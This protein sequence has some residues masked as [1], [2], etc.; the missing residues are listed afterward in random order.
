MKDK[1]INY[2]KNEIYFRVQSSNVHGVGLFAI[3]DILKGTDILVEFEDNSVFFSIEKDKLL[4]IHPNI[5]KLWKDY[6]KND[7]KI[8]YIYLPSNYKYIQVYFMNHSDNPNGYFFTK[9]DGT[10]GFITTRDIKDG[11]EILEDYNLLDVKR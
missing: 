9:K 4:N 6:W 5:R 3:K 11:E 1:L 10:E 2:L 7:S 8:Q